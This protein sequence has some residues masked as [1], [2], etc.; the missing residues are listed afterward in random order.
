MANEALTTVLTVTTTKTLS[1]RIIV[2]II[3]HTL[4]SAT[5]MIYRQFPQPS[6]RLLKRQRNDNAPCDRNSPGSWPGKTPRNDNALAHENA[7]RRNDNARKRK[8]A[9]PRTN[10]RPI[11][12]PSLH[13]TRSTQP[14]LRR[15]VSETI[16]TASTPS[17][18]DP[19]QPN[20]SICPSWY[21][22][23][24]LSSQNVSFPHR[25]NRSMGLL[26]ELSA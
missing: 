4:L 5:V 18:S 6:R 10:T 22:S 2:Y 16:F 24:P 17:Q 8:L 19:Q 21:R 25:T 3:H 9:F 15:T 1:G 7:P 12:L 14:L 13:P 11:T 26:Q 23:P 20:S